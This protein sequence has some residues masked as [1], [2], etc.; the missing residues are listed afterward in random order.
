ML[1][2]R[3]HLITQGATFVALAL[4]FAF[5]IP[6][7][8]GDEIAPRCPFVLD[9]VFESDGYPVS[10]AGYAAALVAI[11]ACW[12]GTGV[13]M[14]IYRRFPRF[15]LSLRV[16]VAKTGAPIALRAGLLTFSVGAAFLILLQLTC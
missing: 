9:Q 1:S 10:P 2:P 12:F 3:G 13:L 7:A 16:A 5:R 4:I 15:F 11:G 6:L 14:L 8:T